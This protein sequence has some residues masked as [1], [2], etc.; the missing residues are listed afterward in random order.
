[1]RRGVIA[2]FFSSMCF[3]TISVKASS[4]ER[5]LLE[6]SPFDRSVQIQ[7]LKKVCEEM[8]CKF[9]ESIQ[10]PQV[11]VSESVTGQQIDIVQSVE[12]QGIPFWALGKGM[13]MYLLKLNI[14]VLGREMKVHNLAHEY[15]HYIQFMYFNYSQEDF[16]GDDLED[17]AVDVQNLFRV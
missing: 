3:F 6:Q 5:G 13:N 15:A 11:I 16:S 14:I 2:L 9:D 17:E 8:A 4:L 7:V 10:L 12:G 1:M